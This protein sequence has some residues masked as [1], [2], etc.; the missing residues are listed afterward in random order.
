MAIRV[1]GLVSGL[2]TDS[3][4]QELV[5]AYSTKKDKYVKAQT[6]LDWK[7]DAWKELNKK[8]NKL[9]K[10]LGNMKLSS[11]YNKKTTTISDSTKATVTA[12][13]SALNGTQKLTINQVASTG[14][15]TGG[16]LKDGTTADSTLGQLG[17]ADGKG[18]I[19]VATKKGTTNIEVS[20]DMTLKK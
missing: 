20:S 16:V 17:M 8:V 6:K 15:I 11:Y 1:S 3:I 18:T 4:V 13:N 12:S 19:A 10:R 2:D 14:Y 9:Y 7:M 5:S